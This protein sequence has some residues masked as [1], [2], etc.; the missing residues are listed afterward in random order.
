MENAS[1]ALPRAG[2]AAGAILAAE[3]L[4]GKTGLHGFEAVVSDLVK[5]GG[6]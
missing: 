4:P 5:G 1:D 3:W 2:F 6:R